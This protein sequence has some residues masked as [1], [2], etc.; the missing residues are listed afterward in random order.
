MTSGIDVANVRRQRTRLWPLALVFVGVA[1]FLHLPGLTD[2]VFNPDEAF[3]ATQ[4]RVLQAGGHLYRE[5]V[6]RKPP[7]VPLIYEA[8]FTTVG[9]SDLRAVRVV[10][11]AA[12][13]LTAFLLAL[14]AR[15][16]WGGRS[17]LW[18]GLLFLASAAA[19]LPGDAQAANFEIFMLP[20]MVL[21]MLFGARG[22]PGASGVAIAVST[23]TKQTA[24]ATLLPLAY[25]AWRS[26]RG[27]GLLRL[28]VGFVV[29]ILVT[30]WW[31]GFRDFIDWNYLGTGGYLDAHG[32]WGFVFGR[33][34]SHTKMY[35]VS[36]AAIIVLAAM[37]WK[38]RAQNLDLWLWLAASA[39]GV[40]AGL[41]FFDHYYLQLAPALA[42]LAAR[43][44]DELSPKLAMVFGAIVFGTAMWFQSSAVTRAAT[45]DDQRLARVAAYVD[46]HTDADAR[47]FVWGHWP[48]LY[49][50][51]HRLPATRFITTGFLTGHSGG[52]PPALVGENL[53][54]PGAW[55][56]FEADLAAHPP[57][58]VLDVSPGNLRSARLYPPEKFPRFARWLHEHYKRAERV[59]GV[60]VYAPRAE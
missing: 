40:I 20:T 25:L 21:A 41:R 14:E 52:R 22:R 37:A 13:A 51:S 55:D 58:L 5:T 31:F 57:T 10:A 28:G 6:D 8:T 2:T 7:V 24:A 56:D 30:A 9:S 54:V 47:I 49:W 26:K 18:A 60:D 39:I 44:L 32:A 48:E 46:L 1:L 27:S 45:Q 36:N 19:L 15:R 59:E 34:Y 50:R 38:R 23:L 17:D 3:L 4:A 43:P 12:E 42:L 16:R 33:G 29:P 11:I 35:V 53:A